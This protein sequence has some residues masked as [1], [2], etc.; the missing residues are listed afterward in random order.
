M[1]F[2]SDLFSAAAWRDRITRRVNPWAR[3]NW[4]TPSSKNSSEIPKIAI[5]TVN[6]NTKQLLARLVFS[7]RRLADTNCSIGPIVV[8]DNNSTDGSVAMIEALARAGVV[9]PVLNKRQLYHGPGLNQGMEYLR[10]KAQQGVPGYADID[11]VFVVDTD[12][13]ICRP[14]VFS[15]AIRSMKLANCHMAGELETEG[16]AAYVDGGYVHVSSLLFDPAVSWRRGFQPFEEHGVP[17]L[18]Y[19]RSIVRHQLPRLNFPFRS[20][21]YLVHLWSGTLKAICSAK[22]SDNKYFDWAAANVA[23]SSLIDQK[24]AYV[25]EEFERIFRAEV[26]VFNEEQLVHACTENTR[27]FLKRPCEVAPPEGFTPSGKLS[28]TG[29]VA[30]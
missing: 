29:F 27:L 4:P 20:H 6:Y 17:A 13:F 30:S 2:R 25:I 1:N 28:D 10:G 22:E 26:P 5:V 14:D 19:Q 16:G 12:V 3:F 9:D 11:Y 23:T 24:T 18:E 7:L 15:H 21:F 8:V